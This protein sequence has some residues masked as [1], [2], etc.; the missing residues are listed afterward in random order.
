MLTVNVWPTAPL[1]FYCYFHLVNHLVTFQI[2]SF[3]FLNYILLF[4]LFY[5]KST[6]T[7]CWNRGFPSRLFRSI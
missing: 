3:F 1:K 5:C 2:A 4:G 6:H 7:Q